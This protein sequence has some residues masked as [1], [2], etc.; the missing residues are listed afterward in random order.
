MK[1]YAL[2][3]NAITFNYFSLGRIETRNINLLPIIEWPDGSP[4]MLANLYII[5]LLNRR[6]RS[7]RTGL[8]TNG[9][10]GGTVGQYASQLSKFVNYCFHNK[11]NFIQ[12]DDGRFTAFIN[13]MTAETNSSDPRL[14][15]RSSE[16]IAATGKVCLDF[17]DYVGRFHG[18]DNF[19]SPRGMIKGEYLSPAKSMGNFKRGGW[20]HHSF[21]SRN[22][23]KRRNPISQDNIWRLREAA[24]N[25]SPSRFHAVRRQCMISIL[26]DLGPRRGE[27][28]LITVKSVLEASRMEE[29]ML[30]IPTLKRESGAYRLIPISRILLAEILKYIQIYRSAIVKNTTGHQNDSGY[31]LISSRTGQGL[32]GGFITKEIS[33]LKLAAGI[34]ERACPHMFR[35]AFCTKLFV[36]LINEHNIENEDAF[37]KALITKE[38][39]KRKVMEWTGHRTLEAVE[40]Y[41]HLAFSQVSNSTKITGSV[42]LIRAKEAFDRRLRE[43]T[44][45]LGF[46]LNIK[47][48]K[49]EV[50]ELQSQFDIDIN[51]Y[52]KNHPTQR[53]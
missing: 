21:G 29:P 39:F 26:E 15:K 2:I 41:I 53:S 33:T 36:Q 4:C 47:Q 12:I 49:K 24:H 23:Q 44:S 9:D 3:K 43:L 30:L 18:E 16:S 6:G 40:H 32:N 28:V 5:S 50:E 20:H 46:S 51:S 1:L 37:R 17:L 45:Q 19:V 11:F 14:P 34:K 48:F 8:S 52:S 38:D 25:F 7:G 10:H 35:H 42:Q 22:S 13:S 27:I 31:L